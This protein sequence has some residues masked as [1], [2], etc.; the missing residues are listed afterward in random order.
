M[1]SALKILNVA[2]CVKTLCSSVSNKFLSSS[3]LNRMQS[4]QQQNVLTALSALNTR[5][6]HSTSPRQ[7]LMEFF[8]D[9]KN[10]SENEVKV[11]R[12]W[13]LEELR[14]KSNK[15]L[16][17]LWY[18]LLKERNMLLTMEH[19]CN[20]KM[21]LF[22]SPERLDKVKISMGNLETVV[23]ERNKAYHLLETGITGERPTRMV[24]NPLGLRHLYRS[25]EHVLPPHM[26]VKWIKSRDIGFGGR[27]VRKF[28]L[29]YREKL[30]NI[31]RKAKN[32]SRNEVM[33]LLRRNPNIDV[34]VLRSKYPNVDIDKLLR[35]D[36]T[37]GHFVPKVGV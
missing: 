10:W 29:L 12:A 32:R 6:F 9:P 35:D 15:E 34:Q 33:M 28:L 1:S 25:C 23:R 18:I 27:A 37:R 4:Q 16:H 17:Q 14:I 3:L 24:H 31:K 7:D 36:K 11:G 26:N 2:K 22:P 20:D 8:D 13:K 21:E 30:Y 19:E 5:T